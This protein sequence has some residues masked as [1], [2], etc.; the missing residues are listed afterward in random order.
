M[1]PAAAGA[2][3]AQGTRER[4]GTISRQVMIWVLA[5]G[6][7]LAC[8]SP[9]RP[10]YP[11][12]AAKASPGA[13]GSDIGACWVQIDEGPH[14]TIPCDEFSPPEPDWVIEVGQRE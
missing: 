11:Q 1:G 6:T 14:I 5:V 13:P 12:E 7:L 3:V 9:R 4:Q 8:A 2:A 10:R